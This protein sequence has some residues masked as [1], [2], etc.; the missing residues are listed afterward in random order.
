MTE[1][2]PARSSDT[3]CAVVAT[4]DG[5][6]IV[7]DTG[8]NLLRKITAEGK[9]LTLPTIFPA[10]VKAGD[11]AKPIGLAITHDGF[12]YVTELD[13]GRVIEIDPGGAAR[14]VS[15]GGAGYADGLDTA[16]FS[17]LAGVAIDRG[18]ISTAIFMLPTA[19]T[20]SCEDC[21]SPAR[22]RL[23]TAPSHKQRASRYRV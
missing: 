16:R 12:L 11:L 13:R 4:R 8:N 17:Q 10:D 15:G 20:T 1:T 14:V 3:P 2:R 5:T 9:V 18:A 21:P 22:Q 6:L 19:P 7:A 23:G